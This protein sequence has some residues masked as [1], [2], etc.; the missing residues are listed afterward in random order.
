MNPRKLLP[1]RLSRTTLRGRLVLAVL[2]L[3]RVAEAAL[4]LGTLTFYTADWSSHWL[5]SDFAQRCEDA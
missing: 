2:H 3:L 1:I 4:Y 5:F